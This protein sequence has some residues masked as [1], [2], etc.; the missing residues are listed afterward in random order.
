MNF[1]AFVDRSCDRSWGD[2]R[3]NG[4]FAL[5]L[6]KNVVNLCDNQFETF[7]DGTG[8]TRNSS[9]TERVEEVCAFRHRYVQG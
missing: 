8:S 1:G 3:K 5:V 7:E 9:E 2:W 6:H 4:F